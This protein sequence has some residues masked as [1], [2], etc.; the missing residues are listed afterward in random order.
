M[1]TGGSSNNHS[2]PVNQ[3]QWPNQPDFKCNK[4]VNDEHKPIKEENL[5]AKEHK[6]D[7]WEALLERNKYWKTLRVTAW[8]LRFLNNSLARRRRA[9]KLTGPL[10]PEEI[11]NAK[12]RWIKKVQSCT[13]PNLE[14]P[15]WE[16][17]KDN[18]GIL[19]CSGRFSGYNPIY[20]EGGLFSEKRIAH[21]HE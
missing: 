2:G 11:G 8:A 1:E 13:S 18:T 21:K 9:T 6:P 5:Y 15:G 12:K 7:E 20:I 4:D 16:L 10:T 17:V 19:S 14:T 3:K